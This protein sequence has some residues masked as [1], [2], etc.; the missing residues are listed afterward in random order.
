[1]QRPGRPAI[2]G[3]QEAYSKEELE[4]AL[5]KLGYKVLSINKKLFDF[6]GGVPLQEVVTFIRL[7]ADLLKQQLTFD[8]ILTLLYEDTAN[9]RMKEVIKVIQ[10]DLKDGK[11]GTEVYGKHEDVFG[12]FAAYMLSVASTS[13][14]M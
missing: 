2:T 3:E 7:S 13:G 11:E 14:N 12:K 9:K 8:E 4:K 10:K 6:K 1:V 5:V